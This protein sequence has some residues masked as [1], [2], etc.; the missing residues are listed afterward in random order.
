[1]KRNQ[2][3]D[4]VIYLWQQ[5]RS[6]LQE[7]LP[8]IRNASPHTVAA[9]RDSLQCFVDFLTE[10]EEIS[11]KQM[12]YSVFSRQHMKEYLHWLNKEQGL[13]PKTC[14]LRL[15]AIRS[16]LE[17]SAQEDLTLMSLFSESCTIKNLKVPVKP[18]EYL[19]KDEM[20]ALLESVETRS[21]TGRRN[22]MMLI[23]EYDTALR[24]GEL[25]CV[26]LC[27]LHLND[28]TPFLTVVGK[29]RRRR[30]VPLMEK[31]VAHLKIHFQEFHS[32]TGP[33]SQRPLFY[34][35]RDGK[36]HM[37]STDSVEK[38]LKKYASLAQIS[39]PGVPQDIS[40][41]VIRKSRAMDLYQ[42]GIPIAYVAQILGHQSV[43]TTTGFYAFAT[44]ETLQE[45]FKLAAPEAYVEEP[46]WNNQEVLAQL[47]SL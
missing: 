4:P 32:D 2:K 34:S 31:T 43:S 18:I 5:L 11:R 3:K 17:Y 10:K 47:Y 36:P 23:F 29:G 46:K 1:M 15:T 33:E 14:N 24:V 26:R 38:L 9:Y 16:F 44:L 20:K 21:K 27:D 12:D 6:Y 37:L 41:H 35:M 45:S 19:Q 7:Y 22:R 28:N 39:C 8:A 30:S 42:A 13:K 25:V 40:C